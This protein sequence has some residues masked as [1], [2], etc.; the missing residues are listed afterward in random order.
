MKSFLAVAAV[1]LSVAF[2][3]SQQDTSQLTKAKVF[4]QGKRQKQ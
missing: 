1:A 2:V 4:L 3:A